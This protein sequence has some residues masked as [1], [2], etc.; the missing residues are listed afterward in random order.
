MEKQKT[1]ET[2]IPRINSEA[3]HMS[4]DHITAEHSTAEH[5][6]TEH[7]TAG[8][9]LGDNQSNKGDDLDLEKQL[10]F[11]E[12]ILYNPRLIYD[13]IAIKLKVLSRRDKILQ[14]KLASY[15]KKNE[16]LNMCIIVVS[17]V[18]GIYE[19]FRAKIDDLVED[20]GLDVTVNLI[21]IFLSGMI[22]CL[23]SII[24]LKKYQEK[25]DN[26]HLTREK[27]SVAR[28][29]LKTVQ[30]HLLFCRS[31]DELIKIKKIYLNSAFN[32]YCQ[33]NA[34]LD[35]Y[36]K[37]I[38]YHKYKDKINYEKEFYKNQKLYREDIMQPLDQENEKKEQNEKKEK[39]ETKQ[40]APFNDTERDNLTNASNEEG[41]KNIGKVDIKKHK[42]FPIADTPLRELSVQI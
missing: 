32:A 1:D 5:S 3:S 15:Q 34:Y 29:N 28:V 40:S 21:P 35:K 8:S 4:A 14:I 24:K 17:S 7:S 36:V 18:L 19:T 10:E 27:V 41:D 2:N 23:A 31:P 22:T 38:D 9:T 26:I 42:P 39:N 12:G 33:G 30:E 25:S 37:D 16:N 20:K 13:N 6:T 11:N